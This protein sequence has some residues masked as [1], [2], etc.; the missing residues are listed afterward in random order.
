MER[1]GEPWKRLSE[2]VPEPFVV[3]THGRA[4]NRPVREHS[5]PRS[6]ESNAHRALLVVRKG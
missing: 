2:A 4:V 5:T 1:T 3:E 6:I